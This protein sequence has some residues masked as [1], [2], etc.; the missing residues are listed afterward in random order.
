VGRA[1]YGLAVDASRHTMTVTIDRAKQITETWTFARTDSDH[2]IIDGTHRGKRLHV[3][4][5][6]EAESRLIGRGF[7]WVNEVPFN[8]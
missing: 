8:Y 4:L 7:H 3:A 6:R 1:A 2:L 5:H